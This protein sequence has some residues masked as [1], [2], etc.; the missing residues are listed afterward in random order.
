MSPFDAPTMRP[1]CVAWR[2][3]R[4]GDKL[5][6]VPYGAAG[7]H[8]KADDSS[9]WVSR[10][11]A[12]TLAKRLVNGLG[13]G[14]GI[15]LGDL[16]DDWYL[17][18]LDLDSCFLDGDLAS[19]AGDILAV[20][21]A[22]A[23]MSPSGA[24]IKAYFYIASG[25]VRPF[26]DRIGVVPGDWGCRR[27]IPGQDSKDH[28]PAIECYCARRY[29]AVTENP[30][31]TGSDCSIRRLDA[32][33]LERLAKLIPKKAGEKKAGGGDTSRSAVAFNKVRQWRQTDAIDSFDAMVAAL[34]ADLDTAAWAR[35]KGEAAGQRELHRLWERTS[36]AEAQLKALNKRYAV[37]NEAGKVVVVEWRRD[38]TLDREVLDRIS[39]D[40]F[41]RLYLNRSIIIPTKNKDG[42][43]ETV[44]LNL[45]QW[46]LCHK[47]RNQFIGGVA[48]DPTGSTLPDVMNLWRGFAVEPKPGNWSLM[49][50]HILRIICAGDRDH[51]EYVFNWL[52]RLFQHPEE[53]GE[54]ALVLCGPKGAGKSILGSYVAR[55]FK[56][57]GL[58]IMHA[59]QLTGRFNEHLRDC[60][61]IFA[62]EAF[63]AGDRAHEG[64]LK[65][66]ITERTF[67]IEG[68]YKAVVTTKNMLHI[69]MASNHDWVVPAS[70][71]ERRYAVFDVLD[72][73]VADRAYFRGLAHQMDS[74]GLAAM[75]WDLQHR[76]ISN[77]EVRDVP[78]TEGLA[79]Q[80]TLSLGS[81]EAWWLEVLTRG[82]LWK[83]KFGTPWFDAWH[84]FVATQLLVESHRQWCVENRRRDIANDVAIGKL[85]SQWYGPSKQAPRAKNADGTYATDAEG[86][87]LK[88]VPVREV[89]TLAGW[90]KE[91]NKQDQLDQEAIVRQARPK[92]YHVGELDGAEG[93]RDTFV[94][95]MPGI[96]VPWRDDDDL[97]D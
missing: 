8:A 30:Y 71:D 35:E 44:T 4:R 17:C 66:L 43:D 84:P 47:D 36:E 54:I 15:Q 94:A 52:A 45:G 93:A 5:T 85:F 23:E 55:A 58:Q 90:E 77:F 53:N 14:I 50:D 26:L 88:D 62:D 72:T 24:G 37:V 92:G 56:N 27:G 31:P 16:G 42:K 11:Q 38:P 68:K 60:C 65:G 80:K 82:Y 29:F 41:R 81:L 34:R 10:A 73:R 74:G 18:G 79:I 2:N 70:M 6:K 13:G 25:D 39:F 83:S 7:R 9:T 57:H 78:Q 89:Q 91:L 1:R 63:V 96:N 67:S 22:Y 40:D 19:W 49:Q 20:I 51:A 12:E 61:V 87:P 33:T 59:S 32:A 21:D 76:D 64:V 69:I 75:I 46:W 3:E 86:K 28:G 48:F 97:D 95:K